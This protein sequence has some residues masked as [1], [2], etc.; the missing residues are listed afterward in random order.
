MTRNDD[1]T[2]TLLRASSGSP[3]A[4]EELFEL[5][6]AELHDR[7]HRLLQREPRDLTLR[8]TDLLHE[9]Y[10]KMIQQSRCEWRSR[11]HFLSVAARAMRRILVDHARRRGRQKRGG[12]WSRTAL[13]TDM[14]VGAEETDALTLAVHEALEEFQEVQPEKAR[15]VEM[16]FFGGLT[17]DEAALVLGISPR[18]AARHWEYAQAWLYR[19]ISSNSGSD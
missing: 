10:L 4:A 14:L 9:A 19:R 17:H 3:G 15:L 18:T 8:T 5:V 16:R 6:Y 1:A 12:E 13:P 2:E 7:A 11:A